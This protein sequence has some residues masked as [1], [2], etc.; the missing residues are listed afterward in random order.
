MPNDAA[1][2]TIRTVLK[3]TTEYFNQRDIESSRVDAEVLLADILKTTR[4]DLY[5]HF[6][7]PL[8]EEEL[9]RFKNVIKQR[10]ARK[11]VAYILGHKEFWSLR[12]MVSKDVLIPRPETEC[13]VEAILEYV[14]SI[15]SSNPL[16]ILELG[17]GSGAI[18]IALASEMPVHIY[19]GTDLSKSAIRIAQENARK[20][21]PAK[22][23][24][25]IVGDWLDMVNPRHPGFD[26][27]LS[28]P[29]YIEAELI[30]TLQ[31]E[32]YRFEPKSALNGGVEGLD[33]LN[34][35]I[36]TASHYLRPGGALFLEIGYD[37]QEAVARIAQASGN[38]LESVFKKD[39]LGHDRIAIIR[40]TC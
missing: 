5:L 9:F 13:L 8:T 26:I 1:T 15:E 25:W 2:W 19:T 27:I 37:Q 14:R 36:P 21:L 16:Q 3:W 38:Y 7:Q 6:D 32:I 10:A 33:C 30:N 35:I 29:P 18:I 22:P 34:R 31:P 17:T 24:N 39:Y 40:S 20:L 23:M 4:I 28:N 11:P 12:F